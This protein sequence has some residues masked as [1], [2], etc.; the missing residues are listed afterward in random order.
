MRVANIRSALTVFS[1]YTHYNY[2]FFSGQS[3]ADL[4]YYAYSVKD[5]TL[6]LLYHIFVKNATLTA[7]KFCEFFT[8][9]HRIM[10]E[11]IIEMWYNV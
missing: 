11:I 8:F 7:N 1:H 3:Y 9:S 6:T 4:K 10:V 5:F 2:T